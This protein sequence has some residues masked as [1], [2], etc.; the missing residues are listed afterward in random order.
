M[1]GCGLSLLLG[2]VNRGLGRDGGIPQGCPLSMMFIVALYLP[3]CKYLAAQES[4]EPQLYADN[5]K[6]V[7]RDPC[8]LLRAAGFTTGNVRLVG[9]ERAPSKRVLMSTSRVTRRD[10]RDWVLTDGGDK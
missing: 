7:S 2:L 10:M 4:V 9:Q 1:L 8:V 6:S 3:W 5:L